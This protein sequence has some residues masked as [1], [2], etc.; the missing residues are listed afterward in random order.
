MTDATI[1]TC[2]CGRSYTLE[3]W[4]KLPWVGEWKDEVETLELR[5]CVCKST[6]AIEINKDG[7]PR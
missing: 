3:Q 7:K 5:N 4:R 2:G 1:K 6:I